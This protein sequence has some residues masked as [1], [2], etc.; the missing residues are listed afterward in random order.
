MSWADLV[1]TSYLLCSFFFKWVITESRRSPV[2]SRAKMSNQTEVPNCVASVE[3]DIKQISPL[4]NN[5]QSK[6]NLFNPISFLHPLNR[7]LRLCHRSRQLISPKMK[8]SMMICLNWSMIHFQRLSTRTLRQN[9]LTCRSLRKR[10]ESQGLKKR[11]SNCKVCK[12]MI[13]MTYIS[14]PR[15]KCRK[16]SRYPNL[17]S[18]TTPPARGF[19]SRL[20]LVWMTQYVDNIV[21]TYFS[22]GP[23]EK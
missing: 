13:P 17:R 4:F 20:Y 12:A 5:S 1:E 8:P 2:H 9:L 22:K 3:G 18:T 7:R 21:V 15:S 23:L 19:I 11:W 14:M 6:W 16:R 10:G